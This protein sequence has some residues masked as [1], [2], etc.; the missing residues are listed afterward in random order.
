MTTTHIKTTVHTTKNLN[1]LVWH[2]TCIEGIYRSLAKEYLR[3]EYLRS[4]LKRGVGALS[5][6]SAFNLEERPCH[7]YSDS[8]PSKQIIITYNGTTSDFEFKS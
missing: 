6:V 1:L 4:P 7:I 2:I 3:V 5:S 8:M